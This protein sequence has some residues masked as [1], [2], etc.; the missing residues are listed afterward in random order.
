[1]ECRI[2]NSWGDAFDAESDYQSIGRFAFQ[3]QFAALVKLTYV[4]SVIPVQ[5]NLVNP[6]PRSTTMEL[7]LA[8]F[9]P[10]RRILN[11]ATDSPSGLQPEKYAS[12]SHPSRALSLGVRGCI[13]REP[14]S[15]T[16]FYMSYQIRR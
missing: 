7:P 3:T 16:S 13:Q 8:P 11:S 12:R 5:T 15:T 10:T 6:V 2:P 4:L 14:L 9:S 1:M